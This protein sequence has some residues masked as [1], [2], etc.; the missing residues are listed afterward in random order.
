MKKRDRVIKT[1]EIEETDIVPITEMD[2]EV[3]IMEAIIGETLS[4]ATSL[5]TPIVTDRRLERKR[6]DFK[7]ECYR[8]VDLD[9]LTVDLSPP[10]GW[11]PRENPD[12]TIVDLW[13]RIL[14]L[15]KEAKAWVPY[16]TVFNLP[17]DY[18]D[19]EFPDPSS[20]GWTYATEYAKKTIG[21]K[22]AIATFMRDPFAHAWEIFT[23]VK[24]V[25]WMYQ[26]PNFI[27]KVIKKL[28]DFN[29]EVIRQ[30][31]EAGADLIISGG[32]YCE[33]KGPMVPLKFFR[34]VILPN[35]KKQVDE[36]HRRGM[37]FI[38]HTDGNVNPLLDD[39]AEIVDGLHSLDPTAGV[40]I[41]EVKAKYGDKLVLMG[42]VSVDNLAM[43]SR[44]EIVEETKTCIHK[45]SPGG[46][47]ILSSS[48]SWAAG[49]KLENCLAMV[50]AGR[51]YGVY[52][53]AI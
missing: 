7:I 24:F 50:E 53:I 14:M 51:R 43:K 33:E 11:K 25:T 38:K 36:A 47:H 1:L 19:F 5:Q 8:K 42:N 26:N 32:D 12:G 13:G 44:E 49:A 39:L 22:M 52:P 37:K 28:S 35:L 10:E 29:I 41:G 9:L 4:V 40:D 17:E 2:M 34:D 16:S 27:G 21:E 48:N 15:D 31:A 30:I 3:P 45:A 18:E 46:G 23:P 20:P 6:T